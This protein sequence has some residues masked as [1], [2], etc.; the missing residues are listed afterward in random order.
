MNRLLL[1]PALLFFG[2]GAWAGDYAAGDLRIKQVWAR[3][4]PPVASA[5]AAF[6]TLDNSRGQD[7]R[8]LSAEAGVS[9]TV[10]LHT[11]LMEGDVMKMRKVESV[12]VPAGQT[13][14]FRPGG[15][16]IMFIGLKA[17][18]VEGSTFPLTL[19]FEKAGAVTVAVAVSQPPE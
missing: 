3:P 13:V 16:H 14:A 18:L 12:E 11:H 1:L 10:E 4:T 15:L 8:L 5:G 7:D 17:P 2:G 9:A 19:N 6:F